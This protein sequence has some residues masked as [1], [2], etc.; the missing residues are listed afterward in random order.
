MISLFKKKKDKVYFDD[1]HK[2]LAKDTK[3]LL[4][5]DLLLFFGIFLGLMVLVYDS[6]ILFNLNGL[7]LVKF[8]I[9]FLIFVLINFKEK[10]SYSF[11]KNINMLEV[12]KIKLE[13]KLIGD[14]NLDKK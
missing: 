1:E 11:E 14:I 9:V 10:N 4:R 5:N 7:M 2:N 8:V 13:K 12:Y 3:K 6:V